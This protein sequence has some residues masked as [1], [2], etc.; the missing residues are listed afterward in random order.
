MIDVLLV[1]DFLLSADDEFGITPP[2]FEPLIPDSDSVDEWAN[3]IRKQSAIDLGEQY[4]CSS[5]R[6]FYPYVR[7]KIE[8]KGV[9]VQCFTDVTIDTARGFSIYNTL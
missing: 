3:A 2:D 7:D 4:K 9:F 5:T 8:T 6:Q 1:R